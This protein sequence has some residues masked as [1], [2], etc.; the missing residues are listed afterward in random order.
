MCRAGAALVLL[1][2]IVYWPTLGNGFIWDDD[3]YV[4]QNAN[5]TSVSGLRDIWCKL[6]ATPQ[7]YP[8]VH[9]TFWLEQRVW[10]VDPRGYHAVNLALHAA[11][12]VL[13]WRLLTRLA[14]PRSVVRGGD[15]RGPPG[16]GRKRGLGDRAEKRVVVPLA[17]GLDARLFAIFTGGS[18]RR[19]V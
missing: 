18:A 4:E 7:Y 2:A 19:V 13:A 6:G 15:F 10:G 16:G 8:L 17:P 3:D 14:V 11:C 9:T 5:L 1:V 12:A